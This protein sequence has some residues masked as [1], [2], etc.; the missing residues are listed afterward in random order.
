MSIVKWMQPCMKYIP[1]VATSFDTKD[2]KYLLSGKD[3][4]LLYPGWNL[5]PD[6]D[7]NNARQHVLTQIHHGDI[8]EKGKKIPAKAAGK[9]K[10]GNEIPATREEVDK[11]GLKSFGLPECLEIIQNCNNPYSLREWIVIGDNRDSVLAPLKKRLEEVEKKV[12]TKPEY[13]TPKKQWQIGGAEKPEINAA[14]YIAGKA[15]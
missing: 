10:E 2:G 5:I 4:V 1:I 7:W 11:V 6:G 8:F 15:L 12:P 14:E 9:D 13:A 3:H